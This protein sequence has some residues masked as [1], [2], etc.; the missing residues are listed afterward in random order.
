MFFVNIAIVIFGILC[1]WYGLTE[2]FFE[3][4]HQ[5]TINKQNRVAYIWPVICMIMGI[6]F[7]LGGAVSLGVG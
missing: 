1:V 7:A 6:I 3:K 4:R 5:A 2:Y